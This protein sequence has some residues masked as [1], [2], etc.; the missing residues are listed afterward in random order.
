MVLPTTDCVRLAL[1]ITNEKQHYIDKVSIKSNRLANWFLLLLFLLVQV[2]DAEI[3]LAFQGG[4]EVVSVGMHRGSEYSERTMGKV[5]LR[6]IPS[7]SRL[8]PEL[9]PIQGPDDKASW[10]SIRDKR[11]AQKC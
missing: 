10:A 11:M 8:G 3:G 4:V 9:G 1:F 7:S 6:F 5:A 2:P